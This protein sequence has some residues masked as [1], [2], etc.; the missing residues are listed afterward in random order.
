M[1]IEDE[2]GVANV[3]VWPKVLERYRKVIMT[4][5]LIE[6]RGTIQRH[7]DI[8]HIVAGHLEDRN[9]WLG[10]LTEAGGPMQT[11]IARADEV[12]RPGPDPATEGMHPR[13]AGH[14]RNE[15]VLPKSRDFH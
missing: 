8:I 2:T 12:V 1:T 5:R 14:P 10:L 3:V 13:W 11:G 9:A 7:E 4:A 6:V 15:R